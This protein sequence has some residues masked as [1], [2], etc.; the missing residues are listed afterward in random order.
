MKV[1]V[2]IT[3]RRQFR[4]LMITVAANLNPIAKPTNSSNIAEDTP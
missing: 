1:Q 4:V 3:G 2:Q